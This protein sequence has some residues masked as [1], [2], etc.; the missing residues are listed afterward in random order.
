ML[1]FSARNTTSLFDRCMT[2]AIYVIDYI[3]GKIIYNSAFGGT[4]KDNS[5]PFIKAKYPK[6]KHTHKLKKK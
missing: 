5:F 1:L 6:R 4:R 2:K 3:S